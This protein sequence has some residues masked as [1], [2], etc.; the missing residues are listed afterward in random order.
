MNLAFLG[1][2]NLVCSVDTIAF[3]ILFNAL[4]RRLV[5][6]GAHHF[7]FGLGY[8]LGLMAGQAGGKVRNPRFRAIISKRYQNLVPVSVTELS[9]VGFDSGQIQPSK[10][11]IFR[12]LTGAV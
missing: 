3:Q 6:E 11:A 5:A 12:Q 4:D 2:L 9:T 10:D 1:F 7:A 8:R